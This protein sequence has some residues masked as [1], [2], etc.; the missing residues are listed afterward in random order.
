MDFPASRSRV[1]WTALAFGVALSYLVFLGAMFVSGFW[2]RDAQGAIIANDF[3]DVFAAGTMANAGH[4]ALAY[5]WA[6]HRAAESAVAGHSFDGYYGWHYPP[7]FLFVAA[8]LARLPYFLSFGFWIAVTLPLYAVAVSR[9][10]NN[11]SAWLFAL[12]FPAVLL[13]AYVGQNGLF[14]AALIG[15]TLLLMEERPWLSGLCLG[16]LAYKPQFGILFP[17]VLLAS[18]Q[19]RVLASASAT[20]LAMI[21]LST[22]AFGAEAWSAF[23]RSIPHTTDMI[24]AGGH[25]GWNKLQTIYGFVR[26]LGGSDHSAWIAQISVSIVLMA[27]V[28]F[29][30]RSNLPF[31]LKA[32]ALCTAALL[33]TPYA[34]IYDFP[35]LAVSIAFL[36]RDRAFDFYETCVAAAA[37]ALIAVFPWA[38]SP[39]ALAS[40]LLVA[41]L[42]T[43][44]TRKHGID[45]P[46]VA[47]QRG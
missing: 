38:G 16:L 7:P 4:A 43:R 24:L 26:W 9:I 41:S 22:L 36:F 10:A 17:V 46:D 2:L 27:G 23:F 6:T 44:R 35:I 18:G 37:V 3:I 8:L 12:A 42:V 19:W 45:L 29:L 5:D 13:N 20:V 30:W 28:A 15:A 34:Y 11:R 47:L 40:T 25:A 39:V 21:A 14:S 31:A 1:D 32:A 33:A